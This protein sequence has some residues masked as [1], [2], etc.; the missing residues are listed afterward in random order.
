MQLTA[1]SVTPFAKRRKKSRPFR[2]QLMQA[3]CVLVLL[4]L[5]WI[6]VQIEL[7]FLLSTD[8]VVTLFLST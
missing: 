3:L 8:A 4:H 5:F 6:Q 2:R 7:Y 1:E